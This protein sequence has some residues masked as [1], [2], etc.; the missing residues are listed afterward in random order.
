M[1]EPL[2]PSASA[3]GTVPNCGDRL[4]TR[5]ALGRNRILG[6]MWEEFITNSRIR[7]T[8][9][10]IAMEDLCLVRQQFNL[11]NFANSKGNLK[12]GEG[13][14]KLWVCLYKLCPFHF[15][16]IQQPGHATCFHELSETL[17]TEVLSEGQAK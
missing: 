13:A 16:P 6:G 1:S 15:L 4:A 9:I 3:I 2:V 12:L 17:G 11:M 5:R 14:I 10:N 8:K 7:G